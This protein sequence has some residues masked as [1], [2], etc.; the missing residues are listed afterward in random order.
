MSKYLNVMSLKSQR[1]A[2]FL[3]IHKSTQMDSQIYT[4][5]SGNFKIQKVDSPGAFPFYYTTINHASGDVF[6]KKP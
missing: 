5:T 1:I 6:H 4:N 2:L 3:K